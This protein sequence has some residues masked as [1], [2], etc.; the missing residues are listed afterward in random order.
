MQSLCQSNLDYRH[1]LDF[2]LRLRVSAVNA[3]LRSLLTL[4]SLPVT[5][6]SAVKNERRAFEQ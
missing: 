4:A 5:C 6:L 3:G 2:S 1:P